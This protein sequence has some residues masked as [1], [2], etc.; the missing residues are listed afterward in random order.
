MQPSCSVART[1]RSIPIP[2]ASYGGVIISMAVR[3]ADRAKASR[4]GMSRRS[5]VVVFV[6]SDLHDLLF[7]VVDERI[8]VGDVLVGELLHLLVGAPALVFRDL[9]IFLRDLQV[10]VAVA[11]DVTDRDAP[12]FSAL[13]H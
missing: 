4:S 9:R 11:T 13:V 6:I 8:D 5:S 2:A 10:V 1:T 3:R 7:F 12:F